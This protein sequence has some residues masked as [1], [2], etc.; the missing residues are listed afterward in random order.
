MRDLLALVE[1]EFLVFDGFLDGE[2]GP[3]VGL[4]VE[5]ACVGA[6]GLSVDG[7]E[8]D[9]AFVLLGD[10]FQCLGESFALFWGFGKNVA[11]RNASL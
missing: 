11:E 10:G 7:G 9:L 8:I 4:E 1:G 5:I 3:F 2:S 6:K